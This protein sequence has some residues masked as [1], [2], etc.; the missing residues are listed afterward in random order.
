MENKIGT[1]RESKF[2][3]L[4]I[5]AMFMIVAAHYAGHGIKHVLAPEALNGFLSG[6]LLNRAFVSFLIPGGKVGVG[7]FFMLTGY[8][9]YGKNIS[10]RKIIKLV[11]E[12]YFYSILIFILW[13]GYK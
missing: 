10:A 6:S 2:E 12:V 13:G 11:A 3:L 5:V 7:I 1:K 4:R 8:F 9:M